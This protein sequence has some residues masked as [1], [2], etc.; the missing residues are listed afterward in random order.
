M[1]TIRAARTRFQLQACRAPMM[2]SFSV[3]RWVFSSDLNSV[4][5]EAAV[6][7]PA[8]HAHH[9]GGANAVPIAG[10]QSAHDAL[11][12][13]V[14]MGLQL[15]RLLPPRAQLRLLGAARARAGCGGRR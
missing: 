14:A 11:F 2:R 1:P 4:L 9:P 3:S 13:R 12:L 8:R 6:E 15:L 5:L 7:G 10:L